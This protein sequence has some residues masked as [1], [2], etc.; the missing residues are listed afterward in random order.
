LALVAAELALLLWW[1][2]QL[3][4]AW[5]QAALALVGVNLLL[6]G[7][8]LRIGGWLTRGPYLPETM[9]GLTKTTRALLG[10]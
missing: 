10:R 9:A 3:G 6:S 2:G 1:H 8:M 4:W 7:A 5:P